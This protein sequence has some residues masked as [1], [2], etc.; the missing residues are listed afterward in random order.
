MDLADADEPE[1]LEALVRFGCDAGEEKTLLESDGEAIAAILARH[2]NRLYDKI[3]GLAPAARRA[4]QA[5]PQRSRSDECTDIS[6][7]AGVLAAS[8]GQCPVGCTMSALN[9]GGLQQQKGP[10]PVSAL[11]PPR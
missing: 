9:R 10:H 2:P 8:S 1:A 11:R 5:H 4:Y 3:D 7:K 6:D